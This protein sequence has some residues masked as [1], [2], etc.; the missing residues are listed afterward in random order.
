MHTQHLIQ[1][2]YDYIVMHGVHVYVGHTMFNLFQVIYALNN[3]DDKKWAEGIT[4]D[5]HK[6]LPKVH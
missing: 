5:N 6:K 3:V 1:I 2:N 4:H